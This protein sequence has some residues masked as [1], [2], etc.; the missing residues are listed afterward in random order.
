[1]RQGRRLA[2]DLGDA[3]IGVAAS[4]PGGALAVPVTTVTAGPGE[5]DALVAL[6]AE[7]EPIEVVVGL[8]RT[9]AGDEGIAAT[10]IRRRA[11][12][13]ASRLATD[14]QLSSAGI[15]V[16]SV[17]LV[18]ERLSTAQAV[19][20]FHQQGIR[21]RDFRRVIDQA[22]AQAILEQALDAERAQGV[23]P[24]EVVSPG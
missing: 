22:A 9:L 19:K 1:M 6:V 3:R 15:P 20:Q 18:D 12:A 10:K 24:G 8:P 17:R 11:E 14:P 21:S 7:Y 23:P 4:D 16:P 2:V 5:L 13:L